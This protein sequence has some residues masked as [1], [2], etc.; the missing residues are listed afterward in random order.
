MQEGEIDV[1]WCVRGEPGLELGGG[2][3]DG[4]VLGGVDIH[5]SATNQLCA[6]G[7]V[8]RML[9]ATLPIR[10]GRGKVSRGSPSPPLLTGNRAFGKR[11]SRDSSAYRVK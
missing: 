5:R 11:Q 8:R 4:L 1:A 2:S 6:C 10:S 9:P 7:R 3:C